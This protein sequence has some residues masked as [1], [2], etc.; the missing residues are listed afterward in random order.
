MPD[1]RSPK[2]QVTFRTLY[3]W[4]QNLE[5][6]PIPWLVSSKTEISQLALLV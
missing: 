6:S 1:A 4:L 5:N 2:P 3:L